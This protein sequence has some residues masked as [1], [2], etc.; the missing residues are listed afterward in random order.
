M[1]ASRLLFFSSSPCFFSLRSFSDSDP[2]ATRARERLTRA[3]EPKRKKRNLRKCL[4]LV[5]N[6]LKMRQCKNIF[7][8][9]F[10]Q[11]ELFRVD[12]PCV[13]VVPADAEAVRADQA[14]VDGVP[15]G[16]GG[17][18][19]GGGEL[20]AARS[21]GGRQGEPLPGNRQQD[22]FDPEPISPLPSSNKLS[23]VLRLILHLSRGMQSLQ[24]SDNNRKPNKG[25]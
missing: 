8:P 3:R 1:Q 2:L 14:E 24:R 4:T 25:D 17:G 23:R 10:S 11:H 20:W 16:G 12:L 5:E 7:V 9:I 21:G 22:I 19:G 15:G 6:V 13:P 18:G